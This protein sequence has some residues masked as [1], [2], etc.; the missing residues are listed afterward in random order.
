V[1]VYEF[2]YENSTVYYSMEYLD[3]VDLKHYIKSCGG[4]LSQENALFIM[5]VITDA[6]LIAHSMNV[7][8]RDI[9]PDNIFV[10]KDGGIKLI[11]F[12]AARQVLAE[13]SKSLSVI[14]KQG[15]APLEQYQRRGKQG[16][17]TDIYA[18]GATLFY[19]LTGK[20]P[21]EATERLDYP[22]IGN[23]ADYGVSAEL[24][25]IIRKCMEVR[26]ADRYQS[27]SLLKED[28]NKLEIA[29]LPLI[30][31]SGKKG[32]YPPT[33]PLTAINEQSLATGTAAAS[34]AA[35][36]RVENDDSDDK[37]SGAP[38]P[39]M[40]SAKGKLVICAAAAVLV[41]GAVIGVVLG[42][43]ARRRAT[44]GGIA[45]ETTPALLAED[46][47]S[48]EQENSKTPDSDEEQSKKATKPNT[49]TS[50]GNK[51]T[52][53]G[54]DRTEPY[55]DKTEP[56]EEETQTQKGG[57]TPAPT[58]KQTEASAQNPKPT[59]KQTEA[60][61]QNPKPT[62]KQTEAPTQK[63]TQRQ[64][65]AP[66]QKP[67]QKQ[68]EAPTQKPTQKQ[69]EA[70]VYVGP[71]PEVEL[72]AT[73]AFTTNYPDYLTATAN[74]RKISISEFIKVA[75]S[76]GGSKYPYVYMIDF[77]AIGADSCTV[78]VT[79]PDG[80]CSD[81]LTLYKV[82]T[83]LSRAKVQESYKRLIISADDLSRVIIMVDGRIMISPDQLTMEF[84]GKYT[85]DF[86]QFG[87][88]EHSYRILSGNTSLSGSIT[89]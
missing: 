76:E 41:L 64:T 74:G 7:L 84:K 26:A 29:L 58:Q 24:W 5:N 86:T 52:E 61:A 23:A 53:N 57:E 78:N 56:Y 83:E 73:G 67:T 14:L 50:N 28:L 72:C 51:T 27:V 25:E 17:W 38:I 21:D 77:D 81:T 71:D 37:K 54:G 33:I 46:D 36:A 60:S 20:L 19:V 4:R 87:T 13:Q 55:D 49:D 44:G 22:D 35:A 48:S 34:V 18:L 42:S 79:L 32:D 11:D 1:N 31:D 89:V 63:P 68:T 88:G 30:A 65:E 39:F 75:Y 59:Q 6:L 80:R 10:M 70:P 85:L 12:G 16:P 8:H 66:T 2:F 15:F 40:R 3:G 82:V 62:Q 43:Q 47:T 9:S 45:E 69:T